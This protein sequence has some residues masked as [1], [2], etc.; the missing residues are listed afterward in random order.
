[1]VRSLKR[2]SPDLVIDAVAGPAL[3]DVDVRPIADADRLGAVGLFESI[4]SLPRHLTLL[5]S[6]RRRFR[7]HRYDLVLLVDY[8]GFHLRVAQSAAKQNIPVLYYLPPQ[9]WAWGGWRVKRLQASVSQ[10]AVALPFEDEFYER[11]GVPCSYV[12]HPLLDRDEVPTSA[13]A[14]AHLDL[15]GEIRTLGLFPGSRRTEVR[16]LWPAMRGAALMLQASLP[17]LEVLVAA[18]PGYQYPGADSFRLVFDHPADVMA[19]S[20]A[21]I[22][23]SGTTTLEAAL[24][25]TPHIIAY[26]MHPATAAVARRLVHVDHVGLVNLL[27]DQPSVPEFLQ[28]EVTSDTLAKAVA[29]LLEHGSVD[30]A[31]Q[32]ASFA[33]VRAKL[34]SPG[35]ADRV[36]KM[37]LDLAA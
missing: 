5:A 36:A 14:R 11:M 33:A 7:E 34:G 6:L 8:P 23:K 28:R 17:G 31:Q 26:A 24:A 19:A 12:G 27:A 16:R 21:A 25:N 18:V 32:R 3:R 1:M 22:C 20:T 10:L 37:A 2:S 29:P 15:A 9:V 35:A 30:A 4:G 13:I